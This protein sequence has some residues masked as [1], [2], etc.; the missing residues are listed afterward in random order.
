VSA[1]DGRLSRNPGRERH[2]EP[3]PTHGGE[4]GKCRSVVASYRRDQRPVNWCFKG[5]GNE[6]Y[7]AMESRTRFW[8]RS[9][10]ETASMFCLYIVR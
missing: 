4:G 10:Y 7:S 5:S 3:T 9:L 8:L 6:L 2:G 1:A